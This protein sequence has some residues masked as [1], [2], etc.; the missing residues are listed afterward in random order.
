MSIYNSIS[1]FITLVFMSGNAHASI[2]SDPQN[3]GIY[4]GSEMGLPE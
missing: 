4:R 1:L 3:V 2:G